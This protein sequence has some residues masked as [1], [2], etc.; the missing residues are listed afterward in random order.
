MGQ[1]RDGTTIGGNGREGSP[2]SCVAIDA[3]GGSVRRRSMRKSTR[4]RHLSMKSDTVRL[5]VETN[6]RR[7]EITKQNNAEDCRQEKVSCLH[8][9]LS[10]ARLYSRIAHDRSHSMTEFSPMIMRPRPLSC[11]YRYPAP[12]RQRCCL[13]SLLCVPGN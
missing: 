5:K 3:G 10:M 13:W 9:L 4:G 6:P 2:T 11:H 1:L 7:R 8:E 12:V